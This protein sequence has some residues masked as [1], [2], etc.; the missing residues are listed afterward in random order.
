MCKFL[1]VSHGRKKNTD[2]FCWGSKNW[3]RGDGE[4]L[5]AVMCEQEHQF[6]WLVML[7]S[8]SVAIVIQT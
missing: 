8:F 7:R 1:Q 3:G 5:H 6:K 2:F 4:G